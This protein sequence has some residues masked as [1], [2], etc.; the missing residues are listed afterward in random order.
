MKSITYGVKQTL[1]QGYGGKMI[2][3]YENILTT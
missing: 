2:S 3:T 1:P